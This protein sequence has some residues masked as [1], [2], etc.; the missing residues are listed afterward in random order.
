MSTVAN[1]KKT[2]GSHWYYS[3]GRPCYELPKADGKGM[4]NPTLADARKLNLLPGVSTIL[5]VLHKEALIQWMIEQAVLAILT[6]PRIEIVVPSVDGD[7]RRLETDD[8]FTKRVL[9]SER[10]QDQESQ[11]ARDR[12]T[13]IHDGLDKLIKGEKV[14][15]DILPWIKPACDA[16]RA[17]GNVIVTEHSICGSG[18][19]GR[20]DLVQQ[21]P[22]CHW[23][24]D[25]KS[26]K[27]LPDPKKGGAWSEHRL[28]LSAYAKA[29]E[30][31]IIN[32][33]RKS[34]PTIK[35]GNVYISTT[36]KG[37][38]VIC[39]HES[40][41]ATYTDGFAPLVRHWQWSNQY[42]PNF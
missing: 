26:A 42:F 38:F 22:A 17:Y 1:V 33:T 25:W 23:I 9:S 31:H 8:E 7:K 14:E 19:G 24:W 6:T 36:E 13:E 30:Q 21:A 37:K 15:D 29:W 34:A 2:E 4:K 39:E 28:Q 27:K 35:T 20:M 10:V 16:I 5:R 32:S 18:Y 3:D 41:E 40:W 11:I 12:G